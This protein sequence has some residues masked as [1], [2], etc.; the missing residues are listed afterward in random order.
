MGQELLASGRCRPAVLLNVLQCT[1]ET[2]TTQKHLAPNVGG[3]KFEKPCSNTKP[4]SL[5]SSPKPQA[6]LHV[7]FG[8]ITNDQLNQG[9]GQCLVLCEMLYGGT[10]RQVTGSTEKWGVS[11]L[12]EKF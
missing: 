8:N 10:R 12:L 7:H 9:P 11:V 1:G 3:A 2:H 6:V 5:S 4:S